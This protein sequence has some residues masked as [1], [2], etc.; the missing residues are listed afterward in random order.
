MQPGAVRRALDV[1]KGKVPAVLL[2]RPERV[3]D[4]V[5]KRKRRVRARYA[6]VHCRACECVSVSVRTGGGMPLP[7]SRLHA[8]SLLMKRFRPPSSLR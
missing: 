4:I 6:H 1:D 2:Q 8:P 5:R 7:P 3:V